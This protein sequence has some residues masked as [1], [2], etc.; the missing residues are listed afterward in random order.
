ME[1]RIL[2]DTLINVVVLSSLYITVAVGFAFLLNILG[3][4]NIAH[5][6]VYM[7]GGYMGYMLIVGLGV[8]PWISLILAAIVMGSFGLFLEKVSFR[9]F[10]GNFNAT[11]AIG[12][13][14]TIILQTSVNI[15][16]VTERNVL[17]A[18]IEGNLDLGITWV[19]Y[20]RIAIFAIGITLLGIITLL[21]NRTKWGLQMQAISQNRQAAALQGISIKR[22]S[23]LAC[24]IGCGL[25]AIA[26]CLM[27]AYLHLTPFMG[28]AI[29]VKLLVIVMV[30]GIG[31][32]GGVFA[33][34]FLIG[35]LDAV[36]PLFLPGNYS[37]VVAIMLA[38]VILLIRPQGFFGREI[39]L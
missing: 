15:L 7:V 33:T 16:T 1:T 34:G 8:N 39:E 4:I 17:P 2:L 28:D 25:A 38:V 3:I 20:E 14:I 36:L 37:S 9:R 31:S 5:G 32:I 18:F 6:A 27:G 12:V 13:A 11:I 22:V 10:A 30:A 24:F 29:L 35:T 23:A 19:S 26:G 21:V